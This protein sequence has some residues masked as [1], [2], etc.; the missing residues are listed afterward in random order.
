MYKTAKE[1]HFLLNPLY[2]DCLEKEMAT[3]SSILAGKSLG[4]RSLVGYSLW[5]LK[6]L[7]MTEKLHFHF[8]SLQLLP[9]LKLLLS[10]SPVLWKPWSNVQF[11]CCLSCCSIGYGWMHVEYFLVL[12]SGSPRFCQ[13]HWLLFLSILCWFLLI[14]LVSLLKIYLFFNW[15]IIALQNF[16]DWSVNVECPR[17]QSLVTFSY[18]SKFP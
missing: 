12:P 6:E 17:V 8:T 4:Q 11:S 15:R 13:L 14:W 16:V 10:R 3:H 7:G 2:S 5:G 18:L 9:S 1:T